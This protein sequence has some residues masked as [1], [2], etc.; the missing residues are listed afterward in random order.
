MISFRKV[1]VLGITLPHSSRVVFGQGLN[2]KIPL[3]IVDDILNSD[4]EKDHEDRW[5]FWVIIGIIGAFFIVGIYFTIR[6]FLRYRS[7]QKQEE[8]VNQHYGQMCRKISMDYL[9]GMHETGEV[10]RIDGDITN[11]DFIQRCGIGGPGN[12]LGAMVPVHAS[13]H[14][15]MTQLREQMVMQKINPRFST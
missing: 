2:I 11:R 10:V 12:T 14:L 7:L 9:L 1:L 4:S 6:G 13:A 8:S 15:D 5:W 3:P